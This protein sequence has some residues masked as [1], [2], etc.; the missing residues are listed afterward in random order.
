MN[1]KM[2]VKNESLEEDWTN[3][4]DWLKSYN[5]NRNN[6]DGEPI[7]NNNNPTD[8]ARASSKEQQEAFEDSVID[9]LEE[10]LDDFT[11][12]SRE[13]KSPLAPVDEDM[14]KIENNSDL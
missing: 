2:I 11:Q 14:I 10:D 1:K 4:E 12:H 6:Q 13:D 7:F 5:F 8:L 9:D 3:N